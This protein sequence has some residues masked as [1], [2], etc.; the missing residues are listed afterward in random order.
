[1]PVHP[2]FRFAS[3]QPATHA[4]HRDDP[5]VARMRAEYQE[6]PGLSLTRAQACRLWGLDPA[7]CQR[8]LDHLVSSGVLTTSGQGCYLVPSAA[9]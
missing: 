1:M 4:E 7:T 9:A 2:S 5:L 8:A 6:M 3:G